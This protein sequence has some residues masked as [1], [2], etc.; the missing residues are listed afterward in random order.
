MIETNTKILVYALSAQKGY[1]CVPICTVCSCAIHTVYLWSIVI[2]FVIYFLFIGAW[3][4]FCAYFCVFLQM[5]ICA[6]VFL[7]FFSP[8]VFLTCKAFKCALSTMICMYLTNSPLFY[9]F[10]FELVLKLKRMQTFHDGDRGRYCSSTF[11]Q[12]VVLLTMAENDRMH[13]STP[14]I[15]Y[16]NLDCLSVTP[17]RLLYVQPAVR[18][19]GHVTEHGVHVLASTLKLDGTVVANYV[20]RSFIDFEC[21]DMMRSPT[22]VMRRFTLPVDCT[23][24]TANVHFSCTSVFHFHISCCT[25]FPP[26]VVD[27]CGVFLLFICLFICLF[28][29]ACIYLNYLCLKTGAIYDDRVLV[30]NPSAH[31]CSHC[32]RRFFIS[33]TCKQKIEDDFH[34][35][36]PRESLVGT[37][38]APSQKEKGE[39]CLMC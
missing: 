8:S 9:I 32:Y 39:Q 21:I 1:V 35:C 37:M 17:G 36:H 10:S 16:L 2:Y 29:R 26:A 19:I 22:Q 38:D 18:R 24:N 20:Q 14:Q 12:Y 15:C 34:Q 33:Y 27:A 5:C 4:V 28:V 25:F 31:P 6:C 7:P 23:L 11:M 13:T 3:C 30:Y